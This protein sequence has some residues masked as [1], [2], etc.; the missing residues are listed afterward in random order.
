MK[1]AR[2]MEEALR[3]YGSAV[4]AAAF[5][6]RRARRAPARFQARLDFKPCGNVR[7]VA[8]AA[9]WRRLLMMR[10]LLGAVSLRTTS[11]RRLGTLLKSGGGCFASS[12]SDATT[13]SSRVY[14][15]GAS[16]SWKLRRAA[17]HERVKG[18]RESACGF[19]VLRKTAA[20]LR[21]KSCAY[22][23]RCAAS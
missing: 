19:S 12:C 21:R 15:T 13:C 14:V 18:I 16:R 5:R 1:F 2:R 8:R 4:R 6:Y 7:S 20:Q 17:A 9:Q 3:H 10:R 11:K 22:Q 23:A